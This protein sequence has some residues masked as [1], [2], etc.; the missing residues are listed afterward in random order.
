MQAPYEL[1]ENTE[2]H[3]SGSANALKVF[4][5]PLSSMHRYGSSLITR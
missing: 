2:L 5:A 3:E 4:P 1:P